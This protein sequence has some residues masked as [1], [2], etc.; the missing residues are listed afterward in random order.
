M[1]GLDSVMWAAGWCAYLGILA[2][3]AFALLLVLVAAALRCRRVMGTSSG[4]K[5]IGVFHP[6]W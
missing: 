4:E 2:T 5:T 6:Y 1:L 3:A